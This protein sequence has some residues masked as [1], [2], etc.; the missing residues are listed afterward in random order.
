M[1]E[2]EFAKNLAKDAGKILKKHF[3]HKLKV[4]DKGDKAA[5][6]CADIESEALIVRKIKQKYPDHSIVAEE[7]KPQIRKSDYEWII[8][9]LD[10]TSNFLM[11]I[12]IFGV[13]IGLAYKG[14]PIVGVLY[15]PITDELCYAEKGK[16]A[17]LNGKRLHVSKKKNL[18]DCF[19]FASRPYKKD[20]LDKVAFHMQNEVFKL[21]YVGCSTFVFASVAKGFA[22][23]GIESGLEL[24]DWAA[25]KVLVEEAGGK[26]THF[27]G[28]KLTLESRNKVLFSNGILHDKMLKIIKQVL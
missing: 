19:A 4:R 1:E 20:D 28:K 9:P 6:T 13:S 17:F 11:D 18:K 23:F 26:V 25:A 5:V 8:D 21:K 22:D 14:E 27:N 15:F 3:G 24:W 2:L 7:M 16:G 12:P 10:G